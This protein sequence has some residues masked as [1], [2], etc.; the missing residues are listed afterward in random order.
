[1]NLRTG[2]R[3]PW[4]GCS[5]FPKCRGRESWTKID[6][7]VQK[8]LETALAVHDSQQPRFE[9]TALDGTPLKEGTPVA[10]LIIPGEEAKLKLHPDYERE[11]RAM[12]ATA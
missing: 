6:A 7:T 1:M 3:G 8:K 2:K 10:A 9:I 4:L 11:Q 12:G 5:K